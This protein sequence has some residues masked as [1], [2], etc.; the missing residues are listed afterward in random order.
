[1]PGGK[2]VI[3]EDNNQKWESPAPFGPSNSILVDD[4]IN[5]TNAPTDL[6]LWPQPVL[7]QS[8]NLIFA[9][10]PVNSS[11]FWRIVSENSQTA[12]LGILCPQNGSYTFRLFN[13]RFQGRV[14]SIRLYGNTLYV[15]AGEGN[16]FTG[17]ERTRIFAIPVQDLKE[18]LN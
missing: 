17:K 8:D 7:L 13:T 3:F 16:S 1:M 9:V 2:L 10:I 15:A 6:H 5:E 12:G 4:M 14:Q 18:S 11:G